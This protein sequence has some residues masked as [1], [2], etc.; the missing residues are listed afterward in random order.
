VCRRTRKNRSPTEEELI[1]IEFREKSHHD[2]DEIIYGVP[3]AALPLEDGKEQARKPLYLVRY[4]ET[5]RSL[6]D[7]ELEQK[8]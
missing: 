2:S 7:D 8:F 1:N 3:L 5:P 6:V 4:E